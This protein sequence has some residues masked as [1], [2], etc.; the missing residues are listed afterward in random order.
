MSKP[1]QSPPFAWFANVQIWAIRKRN[2]FPMLQGYIWLKC[3][4]VVPVL[5]RDGGVWRQA[6]TTRALAFVCSDTTSGKC[7][8][9]TSVSLFA[10]GLKCS[11]IHNETLIYTHLYAKQDLFFHLNCPQIL[12]LVDLLLLY[13]SSSIFTPSRL[14]SL[15]L[16]T[17][18]FSL[19]CSLISQE[20]LRFEADS[21]WCCDY[22][23]D[24]QEKRDKLSRALKPTL[25]CRI[26]FHSVDSRPS[27]D[28]SYAH[29]G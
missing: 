15:F 2:V 26:R 6:E 12:E 11:S 14:H 18:T 22:R 17:V 13:F 1:P 7:C 29:L 5:Q 10:S 3:I 23:E 24:F 16:E 28:W 19:L 20:P 9:W 21:S 8:F 4:G 25:A 27:H